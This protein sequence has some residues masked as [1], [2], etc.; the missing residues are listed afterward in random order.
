MQVGVEV[1]T[2]NAQLT[3]DAIVTSYSL[4]PG[5]S[6]LF[7]THAS[8]GT[9]F[10]VNLGTGNMYAY[11]SSARIVATSKKLICTAFLADG[12]TD[13]PTSLVHLTMVSKLKQRGE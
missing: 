8:G 9:L 2:T 1:F 11:T 6:V 7:G 4:T 12:S 10:D 3:N 13:P 5:H